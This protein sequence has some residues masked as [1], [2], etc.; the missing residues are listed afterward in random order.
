VRARLRVRVRAAHSCVSA[1]SA[2]H[3]AGSAPVRKLSRSTCAPGRARARRAAPGCL[4]LQLRPHP[5]QPTLPYIN[6]RKGLWPHLPSQSAAFT[7]GARSVR[8]RHGSSRRCGARVRARAHERGEVAQVADVGWQGPGDSAR[9][10][11]RQ[12]GRGPNPARRALPSQQPGPRADL[13]HSMAPPN[14]GAVLDVFNVD[15]TP[16]H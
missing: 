5:L 11:A 14:T 9:A 10:G 15:G 1:P 6:K 7:D 13:I 3:S 16:Y 8:N 12:A 4:G 2:P